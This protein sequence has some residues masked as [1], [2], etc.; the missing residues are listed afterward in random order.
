MNEPIADFDDSAWPTP[1]DEA[2][3]A[4]IRATLAKVLDACLA[5]A[6]QGAKS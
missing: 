3:A 4:P 2:Y 5:F 1:F 6:R